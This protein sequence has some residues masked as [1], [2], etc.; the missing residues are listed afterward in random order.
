MTDIANGSVSLVDLDS[1]DVR[2]TRGLVLRYTI[3]F[4]SQVAEFENRRNTLDKNIPID[5]S[6][7]VPGQAASVF[8]YNY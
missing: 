3:F 4:E 7:S 2:I 8:I 1:A 5:R 6:V